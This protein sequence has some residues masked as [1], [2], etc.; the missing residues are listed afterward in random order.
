[1]IWTGLKKV[2]SNLFL[3]KLKQPVPI[4]KEEKVSLLF[5]LVKLFWAPLMIIFAINNA[6][7]FYNLLKRYSIWDFNAQSF[8]NLYFPLY[9][10]AIFILD[11]VIFSCGYLFESPALKN[12]TKSVEPTV[13]GWISALVCY[14]P[15]FDTFTRI[16]GP[17][18]QDFADFK[19]VSLNVVFGLITIIFFS[20]YVWASTALG[21]KASNLTNRGIVSKGP[22]KYVRHPAYIS[23]NLGWWVASIPLIGIYG[24]KVIVGLAVWTFVYYVRALTEERHLLQDPDYVEYCKKVKY[25][26]IPGII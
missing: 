4:T 15:F 10:S 19:N 14:G 23:K 1:M 7:D 6:T 5:Y 9:I 20:I 11:T 3:N 2:F 24:W 16:A 8:L 25:M 17:L 21:F 22:Y 26:F 13:L 18:P 12:L